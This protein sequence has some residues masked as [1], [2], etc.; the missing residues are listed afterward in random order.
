MRAE[1][2]NITAAQKETRRHEKNKTVLHFF[3]HLCVNKNTTKIFEEPYIYILYVAGSFMYN[4]NQL[5]VVYKHGKINHSTRNNCL[6]ALSSPLKVRLKTC[7]SRKKLSSLAKSNLDSV[8][9]LFQRMKQ[10]APRFP[11]K[12][13]GRT[14]LLLSR[15]EVWKSSTLFS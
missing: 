5:A 3:A 15:F 14:R 13:A 11:L 12:A 8:L 9:F 2:T 4:V 1:K 6:D 10:R 7:S